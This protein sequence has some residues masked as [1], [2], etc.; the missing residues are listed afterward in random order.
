MKTKQNYTYIG[1]TYT[2]PEPI[3]KMDS[4]LVFLKVW[5]CKDH[6]T[7]LQDLKNS[8]V[9]SPGSFVVKTHR[10]A[11]SDLILSTYHL[12]IEKKKWRSCNIECTLHIE[13]G[14]VPVSEKD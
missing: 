12:E 14:F 8:L 4:V 1:D 5:L 13:K 2:T 10:I 3:F 9:K 6:L 7:T 11:W